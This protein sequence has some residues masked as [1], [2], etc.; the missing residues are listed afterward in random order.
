PPQVKYW[1]LGNEIWGP[2]QVAQLSAPAYS[3]LAYQYA[4]ALKLLDPSITLILCGETG[5]SSWD[6]TVLTSCV[7]HDV[8]G[9]GGDPTKRL[10]D[11]H[12]IHV[13]TADGDA[14]ANAVAP[15]AAERA[16]QMAMALVDLARIENG[17]PAAVPRPTICFD[18][19]NVWDP[20]RAPGEQGAEEKYTLSDA[21]AVGVWL[22][23]FVRQAASVGMANIA[24]SVNVISPLMTT[25]TGVVRQTTWWPLLLFSRF[26]RGHSVALSVRAPEYLG[27]TNPAWIRGT[28]ETPF[29]DASAALGED[30][31]VTLAVVNVHEE[32]DFEVEL[33]GVK[34]GKVDVY[35]VT[36][37][38]AAVV[39]T[40]GEEKV[41]IK[42]SSWDGVGKYT[43]GKSSLTLLRWK[44]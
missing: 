11:M 37:E 21:L 5:Y 30:G 16:I 42:E 41:G 20:V 10:I 22:N 14:V 9:L 36:G 32:R 15:R 1:A 13:Y 34:E 44:A 23:V 7:K 24:Q 8:H 26:M 3:A 33:K 29:L 43:F 19:W 39:N 4:K 40:E 6:H 25:P 28:I 17:V 2:W 31:W 35:T 12:S 27:R 18:E 38:S